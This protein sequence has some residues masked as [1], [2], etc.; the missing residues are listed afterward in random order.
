MST[1]IFCLSIAIPVFLIGVGV[2][3]ALVVRGIK[4]DA[5]EMEKRQRAMDERFNAT[6]KKR[7]MKSL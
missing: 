6:G 7:T 2:G 5:D 1:L 3:I 4:T